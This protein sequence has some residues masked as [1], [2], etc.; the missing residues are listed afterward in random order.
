M[1]LY[2]RDGGTIEVPGPTR[3]EEAKYLK[4]KFAEHDEASIAVDETLMRFIRRNSLNLA[5]IANEV[6]AAKGVTTADATAIVLQM[7]A[8]ATGSLRNLSH[9][10]ND[11][12]VQQLCEKHDADSFQPYAPCPPVEKP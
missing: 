8:I 1:K 7:A 6:A 4:A 9:E 10:F 2:K 11:H 5:Q 3:V 12:F